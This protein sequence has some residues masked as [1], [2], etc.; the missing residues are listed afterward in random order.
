MVRPITARRRR[1]KISMFGKRFSK[2]AGFCAL[3]AVLGCGETR[4]R[5]SSPSVNRM[6]R[7]TGDA[8]QRRD[9][10]AICRPLASWAPLPWRTSVRAAL[11]RDRNQLHNGRISAV[12]RAGV[13]RDI[14]WSSGVKYGRIVGSPSRRLP[15]SGCCASAVS[16]T[17][18]ARASP[19]GSRC[20]CGGIAAVVHAA[21]R[22]ARWDRFRG[23]ARAAPA[24]AERAATFHSD[25]DDGGMGSAQR[26]RARDRHLQFG[27]E[28][29]RLAPAIIR[30]RGGVGLA[31]SVRD[32]GRDRPVVCRTRC[33]GRP[34]RPR[35]TMTST[36]PRTK[37]KHSTPPM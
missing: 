26:A 29:Q 22:W 18:S 20:W 13:R 27:R 2:P 14:R 21:R 10:I 16:S 1:I 31:H 5:R 11:F 12:T 23:R 6:C 7:A 15:R 34:M 4:P 28:H 17:G 30:A 19:T 35:G 25:G 32:R 9:V 36:T 8:A 3:R 24:W 33:T 37:S